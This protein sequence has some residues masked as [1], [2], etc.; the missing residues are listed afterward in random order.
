MIIDKFKLFESLSI[1]AIER[2]EHRTILNE[3]EMLDEGILSSIT[4]FFSRMLG[5]SVAKIDKILR[6]Y[7][8]AEL[9]YWIDWAD[10]R[11][12]FSEADAL[13]KEAKSDPIQK[14]KY[15]EQKE[16]IKKLQSQV[17]GK[18]KD[19]LDALT[20][21]ANAIIKDS[22]RLKDYWEM[23]KAK[24]DEDVARES[25]KE[26]KNST[27]DE[28]IHQLFDNEI[29]RAAKIARD[30]DAKFKE[31]YGPLS[32]GKFFDQAP[33]AGSND[34][35]DLSVA[36]IKITDL[37][38][39]PISELQSKLKVIPLDK[40]DEIL[41]YLEKELKKIKD[42][43]DDDIKNIKGK[44]DK[45]Q[46]GREIDDITKKVKPIIDV[47]WSKINYIDQLLLANVGIDKEIKK[48]PEMV[49]DITKKE[50]GAEGTDKAVTAAI[51]QTAEVVKKPDVDAVTEVISDQVKKNFDTAR[52]TIEE[53]VGE[54]IDDDAYTHLKND[55]I[56]LYGKLVIYYNKL[57]KGVP[58]KTLEFGLIDFA[59]QLYKFKKENDSLK[60]D[61][62]D[63]ELE[64]QL[65]KYSK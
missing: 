6:R 50:L 39:K 14:S 53:S 27:D 1:G 37:I 9:E 63:D 45:D 49:T 62:T 28:T 33:N 58:S 35:D 7:E 25:Y 21:Q 10:A 24:I 47:M 16:R 20:R 19:I 56:A 55:M 12:K 34:D 38:S 44:S 15:E 36:G 2:G 65:D 29:Q 23:K 11:G 40:L 26:V 32:S 4:N 41:K 3:S 48:N 43:R 8:D 42:Q 5:G 17:E 22:E 30:K 31:K 60:K 46:I 59:A 57:K 64:K 18:R 54:S 51:A 13:S 52:G 61:L